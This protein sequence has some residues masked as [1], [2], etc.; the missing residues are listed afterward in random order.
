[1]ANPDIAFPN[2][3]TMLPSVMMVKSLVHS[4]GVFLRS[5][6]ALSPLILNS[7]ASWAKLILRQAVNSS[8]LMYSPQARRN[9]EQDPEKMPADKP[10]KK[11]KQISMLTQA[12]KRLGDFLANISHEIRT[13]INAILGLCNMSI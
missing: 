11:K 4:E 10:G 12:T 1:M 8:K 6:I 7:G 3:D 13:P 2:I 9:D 5:D